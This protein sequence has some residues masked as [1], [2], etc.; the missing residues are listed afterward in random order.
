MRRLFF[1]AI[2]AVIGLASCKK[3]TTD[4]ITLTGTYT[5]TFVR[6]GPAVDGIPASVT[7][8]FTG[9]EFSGTGQL[10]TY[11]ALCNGTFSINGNKGTFENKCVWTANFD[12]TLILNGEY[13]IHID[14]DNLYIY[15]SYNGAYFDS[16]NLKRKN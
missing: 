10:P 5:G 6:Y 11:P 15:R 3:D 2:I 13:D 14:G 8:T 16:Y 12:W 4:N 7:I 1:M 9:N